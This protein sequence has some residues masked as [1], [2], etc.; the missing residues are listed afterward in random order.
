MIP[1][2]QLN[3]AIPLLAD[4]LPAVETLFLIGLNWRALDIPVQTRFLHAFPHLIELEII[5][6]RFQ[7]LGQ[8]VE[9][10]TSF[11]DLDYLTVKKPQWDRPT[12]PMQLPK[13]ILSLKKL[14]LYPAEHRIINLLKCPNLEMISLDDITK[15]QIPAVRD[16][17]HRVGPAL[18]KLRIRF[19]DNIYIKGAL[20]PIPVYQKFTQEH[21]CL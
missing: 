12:M 15:E 2:H 20:C 6:C 21:R 11:R 3:K 7:T 14:L 19:T 17:L 10:V 13:P 18:R 4:H 5:E 16:L 1:P 8:L 9:F